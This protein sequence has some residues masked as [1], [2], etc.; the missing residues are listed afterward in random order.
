MEVDM[1]NFNKNLKPCTLHLMNGNTFPFTPE[2][3]RFH[4]LSRF[5]SPILLALTLFLLTFVWS[6]SQFFTGMPTLQEGFL[7]TYSGGKSPFSAFHYA[8]MT[9]MLDLPS[10]LS[11]FT[12][13]FSEKR[14][15]VFSFK[16]IYLAPLAPNTNLAHETF[17][18]YIICGIRTVCSFLSIFKNRTSY[19]FEGRFDFLK[20]S[21]FKWG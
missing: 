10:L 5:P 7:N 2:L 12:K 16:I 20:K 13:W 18:M 17:A 6:P 8:L 1:M 3:C 11:I 4:S 21:K 14:T 19:T 15:M 9:T